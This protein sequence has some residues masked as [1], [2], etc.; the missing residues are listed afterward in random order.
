[1][2]QAEEAS[3]ARH[4]DE[5]DIS[6]SQ[7]DAQS[8]WRYLSSEDEDDFMD[9]CIFEVLGDCSRAGRGAAKKIL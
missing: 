2:G 5:A 4:Y 6:L 3:R 8:A 1:M 9:R 7:R